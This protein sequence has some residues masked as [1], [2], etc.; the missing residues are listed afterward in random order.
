MTEETPT[1]QTTHQSNTAQPPDR[2]WVN[3]TNINRISEMVFRQQQKDKA[4]SENTGDDSSDTPQ[5]SDP[6]F[7]NIPVVPPSQHIRFNLM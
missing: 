4:S 3:D 6:A 5:Y 1:T 7:N 2:M